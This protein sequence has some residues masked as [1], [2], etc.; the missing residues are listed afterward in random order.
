MDLTL[1]FNNNDISL[2]SATRTVVAIPPEQRLQQFQG[3][4]KV[5]KSTNMK[6]LTNQLASGTDVFK[7][8]L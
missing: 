3:N 5:K 2:P 4:G 6:C 8:Y 7:N 1:N